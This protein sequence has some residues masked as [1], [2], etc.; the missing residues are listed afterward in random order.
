MVQ[1]GIIE[2]TKQRYIILDALRGLAILGIC[3]ANFPEFSL[4]TF[5]DTSMQQSLPTTGIDMV[6]KYFQ[7]TFIDGK[8]YT[9]F[10]LL[11]GIGFSIILVNSEQN[12]RNGVKIFYRRMSVLFLIGL[13]HL[14]FLWAGDILVLYAFLGFFLS[15]FRKVS[16][17]GLIIW[18]AMLLL[19]PIVID[20]G[21]ELFS[22]NLS[23]PVIAA[24]K[25]F[26][27]QFGITEQNF[28]VWLVESKNYINVLKF[29]LAGS[30]IRMQEFIDGNR[31]FKVMG[32]FL[33]GL[34]I[35]RRGIYRNLHENKGL[36]RKVMRYGFFIGFPSSL[37]YAWSAMNGHPL[38]LAV[39]SLIYALSVVPFALFYI[40]AICLWY[41]RDEEQ[42]VFKLFAFPGRMALTNY[43]M[44]SAFGIII[45][46]GIGFAMGAKTGLIYVELIA[47]AVFC[48]QIIYSYLWLHYFRFGPLE[49][50]WRMLT[51]SKWMKLVK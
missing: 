14:I 48:I 21:V 1:N 36:L 22:W 6:V 8:F 11:F 44:Q 10:S 18:A 37:L 32:L 15:L 30:F 19:L 26:H 4:Y 2:V 51:Y 27:N 41:I 3:L 31:A 12:N 45:F 9:L 7:Y 28:P 49:W 46:Y 29:N 42:K 13:F 43:L 23:T 20:A 25:Y 50:I 40:S 17:R 16:D 39:H 47:I 24:T 38:G 5:Q 35:G 34:Y 33:L